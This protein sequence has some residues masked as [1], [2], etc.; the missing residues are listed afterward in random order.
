MEEFGFEDLITSKTDDL[1][2]DPPA[3]TGDAFNINI[4]V[5]KES[6]GT[7]GPLISVNPPSSLNPPTPDLPTTVSPFADL[8]IAALSA[9][10]QCSGGEN[11]INL[12]NN[13]DPSVV[14]EAKLAAPDVSKVMTEADAPAQILTEADAPA[15]ILTEADSP[16]EILTEAS[17]M[18][19][20]SEIVTSESIDSKLETEA[21]DKGG[22]STQTVRRS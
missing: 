2:T 9:A 1:A 5:R 19:A 17:V 21:S 15:Q 3:L 7:L 13:V 6:L 4:A 8:A 20:P 10:A 16:A 18:S 22:F 12:L 14:A 11:F